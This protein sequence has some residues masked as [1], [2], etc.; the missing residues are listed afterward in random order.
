MAIGNLWISLMAPFTYVYDRNGE[1]R[2]TLQFTAAGVIA[3]T[4][5]FFTADGRVL[6]A[7]GCYAFTGK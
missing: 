3:P 1:K 7:P 5:F 6:V 4:S 2:H